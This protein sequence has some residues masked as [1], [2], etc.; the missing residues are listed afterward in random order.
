MK[1]QNTT[2][3]FSSV[4]VSA[5][6][7]TQHLH[8]E[9]ELIYVINGSVNVFVSD[10]KS[11]LKEG[12]II[13]INSNTVHF[14]Q[15]MDKSMIS[16]IY[17]SYEMISKMMGEE[18]IVF[19]CNSV[20]SN[21]TE[22]ETLC[23]LIRQI[24]LL[25]LNK[26]SERIFELHARYF[27][28]IDYLVQNFKISTSRWLENASITNE[29][30]K[31]RE[32][33]EYIDNNYQHDISLNMLADKLYLSASSVSRIF[34]RE[35]GIKFP[36]YVN[37]IRL[38][39]AVGELLYTNKTITEIAVDN[40]FS[41]PSAFN[42]IFRDKYSTTPTQYKKSMRYAIIDERSDLTDDEKQK[43]SVFM[44]RQQKSF[45][46][47]DG[48][49]VIYF[50]A[51]TKEV[52]RPVACGAVSFGAIH[53]LSD[54]IMQE[55]L[56]F[57][58]DNL[59]LEYVR[60]WNI[61]S[62]KSM[63]I[64]DLKTRKINFEY[65]DHIFDYLLSL[66]VKPYIDM[67]SHLECVVLNRHESLYDE[68]DTIIFENKE[69]W[70]YFFECFMEHIVFRYGEEEVGQWV[71]EFSRLPIDVSYYYGETY[72]DVFCCGYQIVKEKCPN[73]KVAGPGWSLNWKEEH[74]RELFGKWMDQPAIPDI[75]SFIILP[76]Q[77]D[78][79]GGVYE[80]N[81]IFDI[82]YIKNQ[83]HKMKQALKDVHFPERPFYIVEISSMVSN[84]NFL[85][86]HLGRGTYMI[87]MADQ[88]Q[89]DVD[90]I[91]TWIATDRVDFKHA[92]EGLLHGGTGVLTKDK[93]PKPAFYAVLFL[94][95]LGRYKMGN[96]VGYIAT[97]K[98]SKSF[99][100]LLYN[101]HKLSYR[102]L[103]QEENQITL[104]NLDMMY[105]YNRCE[106]RSFCL[107][108]LEEDAEYVIKSRVVNSD[109]GSVL[110]E[111]KR[112]GYESDLRSED[113]AY[114]Q[115]ICNPRVYLER[116]TAKEGAI[117]MTVTLQ[118]HEIRLIHIY[119]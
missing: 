34:K 119:R 81:R 16:N 85:N 76:C 17:I 55:H 62:P 75:L 72:F 2:R 28:L 21:E 7:E 94:N 112:L 10:N 80:K 51:N 91:F 110:D 47:P 30:Y 11:H 86:D 82:Q 50:D 6:N 43:L 29:R 68:K 71:I 61:F 107:K 101:F 40:G 103:L 26:S 9:I 22:Y 65:L 88:L 12:D 1:S 83:I 84:R 56:R 100:I 49:E 117:S 20:G 27:Q 60:I 99:Y 95:K 58:A 44:E 45:K 36:D 97:S 78:F 108:N 53:K 25:E 109:Q 87:C 23:D 59:H 69:Q 52:Y 115:S 113:I 98:L 67:G 57:L 13:L 90:R 54:S 32:V 8:K 46:Q 38:Q 14:I 4:V 106:T 116:K 3:Y 15:T 104:Q 92:P 111:W 73:C 102:F 37:Q 18:G 64:E 96:G 19:W 118:P 48:E 41:S 89:N 31:I 114:L 77:D 5:R 66:R 39:H 33:L 93:L 74:W 79:L 42:R 70:A 35:T 63:I 24:I 105:Q